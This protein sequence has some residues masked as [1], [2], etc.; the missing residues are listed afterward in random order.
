MKIRGFS[1][2]NFRAFRKLTGQLHPG[3]T[4]LYGGNGQGKSAVL[5]ALAVGVSPF[6]G[7]F[8]HGRTLGF[9]PKD[10]RVD[11]AD[12][13]QYPV[14]LE[15]YGEGF[16]SRR[17][18]SSPHSRTTYKEAASLIRMGEGLQEAVRN[19]EDVLLPV[20]AYYGTS[21]LWKHKRMTKG[22][23]A[24]KGRG[25]G[26]LDCLDPDSNFEFCRDWYL[27]KVGE[28]SRLI[29]ESV[30][31]NRPQNMSAFEELL[32]ARVAVD[33]LLERFG[34]QLAHYHPRSLDE[35][36]LK[37]SSGATLEM[38]QLSD[39]IRGV[40][41]LAMDLAVRCIKLN[42][43]LRREANLAPG[44]VMVDELELHLHPAWQQHIVED[45]RTTFPNV[46]WVFTTHSPQI[47]T[48]VSR[49]QVRHFES[50]GDE[51]SLVCPEQP[52]E[53]WSSDGALANLME[54][55]P[56]PDTM[57]VR[58][59]DAVLNDAYRGEINQAYLEI[60]RLKERYGAEHPKLL[61]AEM[62][63]LRRRGH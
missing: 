19:G 30:R 6:V 27:Q 63:V 39:G 44:I 1:V 21:R 36:V 15:V 61:Q 53:G 23:L 54:V 34:A 24:A 32:P 56:Y 37:L 42:P 48:T 50:D 28:E 2:E 29:L 35:V 41:S 14:V 47:L 59:I 22:K 57:A 5:D 58:E 49:E 31:M 20:I 12:E 18:L 33:N 62:A 46:Q 16:T 43:H 10:A 3:C 26:Y 51:V 17:V 40:L 52:A 25:A 13:L 60:R 38:S 45:L 55:D 8:D 11:S 4:V 9:S 7:A